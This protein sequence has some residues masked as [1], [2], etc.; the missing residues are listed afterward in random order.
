MYKNE[1]TSAVG[2]SLTLRAVG[3]GNV[4]LGD[5]IK[6][7]DVGGISSSRSSKNFGIV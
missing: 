3:E 1:I 2:T 7:D 5:V 4:S 6:S